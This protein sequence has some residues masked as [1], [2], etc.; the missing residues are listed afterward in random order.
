MFN[1]KPKISLHSKVLTK[2]NFKRPIYERTNEIML[3]KE[4]KMKL[5]KHKI[6]QERLF[7]DLNSEQFKLQEEIDDLLNS[8][9]DVDE[10]L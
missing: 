6:Q 7:K 10:L 9:P 3:R 5:L 2:Q 8:I 4:K 1:H